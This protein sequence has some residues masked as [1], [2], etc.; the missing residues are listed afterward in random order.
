MDTLFK[1]FITRK[2]R[3]IKTLGGLEIYSVPVSALEEYFKDK[4]IIRNQIQCC[5]CT[6]Y[7][8]CCNADFDME[9]CDNFF[10]IEIMN[11]Y[12]EEVQ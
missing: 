6:E 7:V 11:D 5:E 8:R 10:R 2:Q 9:Y 12:I 1:D 4:E 3:K